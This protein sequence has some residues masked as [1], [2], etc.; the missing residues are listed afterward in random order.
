MPDAA[1][2][3]TLKAHDIEEEEGAKDG[4]VGTLVD[5]EQAVLVVEREEIGKRSWERFIMEKYCGIPTFV[6]VIF[7]T[8][9]FNHGHV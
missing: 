4:A 9:I 6:N 1:S 5:L 7:V 3:K 2:S 8:A